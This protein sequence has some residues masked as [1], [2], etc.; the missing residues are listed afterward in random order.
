MQEKL[1][2]GIM[3]PQKI[4]FTTDDEF[5]KQK[6]EQLNKSSTNNFRTSRCRGLISMFTNSCVLAVLATNGTRETKRLWNSFRLL[7][8]FCCHLPPLQRSNHR[9]LWKCYLQLFST[10]TLM[11]LIF[12]TRIFSRKQIVAEFFKNFSPEFQP[13]KQLALPLLLA[14]SWNKIY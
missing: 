5:I 12:L 13:Q 2:N 1:E 6:A 4:L 7:Q 10:S 9:K 11:H 3:G 14:K 8:E